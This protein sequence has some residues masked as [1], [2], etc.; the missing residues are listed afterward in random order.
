M[1][2]VFW[3]NGMPRAARVAGSGS[4]QR[5]AL[6]DGSV[7][8]GRIQ[9]DPAVDLYAY[10]EEGPV[11]GLHQTAQAP[12]VSNDGWTVRAIRTVAWKSAATIRAARVA[13]VNA[14]AH[15]LL[16]GTDWYVL[17]AA[18]DP[19]KP[20]PSVVAT[21]R[22]AVRQAANDFVAAAELETDP[23]VLAG[24]TP[25]WPDLSEE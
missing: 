21:Y 3:N 10:V 6:P 12:S 5:L 25:A 15:G 22:A 23:T 14:T 9:P 19:A 11:P 24:L 8:M 4:R 16:A 7:R 2:F 20:V 1:S 17:R 18:D 13:D